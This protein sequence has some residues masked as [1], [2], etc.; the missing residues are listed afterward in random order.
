MNRNKYKRQSIFLALLCAAMLAAFFSVGA[1]DFH[2]AKKEADFYQKMVSL[3]EYDRA[4]GIAPEARR[5]WPDY[6]NLYGGS[7]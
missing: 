7:R 6:R 5:G 1:S 4:A 2:A 3:Y